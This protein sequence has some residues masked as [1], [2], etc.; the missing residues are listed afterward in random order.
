MSK[1]SAQVRHGYRRKFIVNE[2]LTN[3]LLWF[4]SNK[5]NVAVA[6]N[7]E[8]IRETVVQKI[9]IL[10]TVDKIRRF[11]FQYSSNKTRFCS[12]A[13]LKWNPWTLKMNLMYSE[14]NL[15]QNPLKCTD[16]GVRSGLREDRPLGLSEVCRHG[17]STVLSKGK[18]PNVEVRNN[19]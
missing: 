10:Q 8:W 2:R 4:S 15:F 12:L 19:S 5:W 13:A 9:I 3:A 18:Y 7:L 11:F 6:D 17:R 14:I 1:Y 16:W